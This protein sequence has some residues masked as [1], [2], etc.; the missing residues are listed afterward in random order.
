[1]C[2]KKRLGYSFVIAFLSF[3]YF[4][5]N[6]QDYYQPVAFKSINESCGKI[7][8]Y[9]NPVM[10]NSFFDL[11]IDSSSNAS[12]VQLLIYNPSGF[13]KKEEMLKVQKGN[14]KFE[15]NLGG[16]DPGNYIV[17]IVGNNPLLYSYS[18]QLVVN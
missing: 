1:M 9:P 2:M 8:I 3:M 18:A 15:V 14:N 5:A 11:E 7:A 6:A 4:G 17:R 12:I 10:V 16:Y 13:V